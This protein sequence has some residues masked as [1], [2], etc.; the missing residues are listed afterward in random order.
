MVTRKIGA[1]SREYLHIEYA[2]GDTL[3]VPITQADRLTRYVGPDKK[4]PSLS[5]LGGA[6]WTR[7]RERTQVAVEEVAKDLLGNCTHSVRS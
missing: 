1:I 3:Y 6:E 7:S 2:K 4:Q 5:H